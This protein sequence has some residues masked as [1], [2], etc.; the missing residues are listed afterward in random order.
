MLDT[1]D[2]PWDGPPRPSQRPQVKQ[3]ESARVE[4]SESLTS[5]TGAPRSDATVADESVLANE[6][7]F[8]SCLGRY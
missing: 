7:T 4:G 1:V 5:L 6:P 8:M 3:P 2:L